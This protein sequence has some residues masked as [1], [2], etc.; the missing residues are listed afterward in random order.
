[1]VPKEALPPGEEKSSE[2]D[3]EANEIRHMTDKRYRLV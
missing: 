3:E 1:L 2:K